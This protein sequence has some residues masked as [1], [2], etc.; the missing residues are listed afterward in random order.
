MIA[1]IIF[2]AIMYIAYKLPEWQASN[3]L[4]PPGYEIDHL[5]RGNDILINGMSIRDTYLKE[6]RGGYDI[7]KKGNYVWNEK[8]RKLERK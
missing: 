5:Q 4:P 3:R 7:P 8:T 1:S 6:L 2:I